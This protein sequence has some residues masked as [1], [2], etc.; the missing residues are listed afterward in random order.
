MAT[1][2]ASK[3]PAHVRG[4]HLHIRLGDPQGF[5]DQVA[6]GKWRLRAR[7]Q[8]HFTVFFHLSNRYVWFDGHMLDVRYAILAFDDRRALFPGCF[9]IPFTDAEMIG[10]IGARFREDKIG[11]LVFSEIGV[12]QRRFGAGAKFGVK[13]PWYGFVFHLDQVEG[14]FRD[15]LA[16]RRHSSHRIAH[17]A[18][19]ITAEYVAVLQVK[20][21]V[22]GER[23]AS[24]NGFDAR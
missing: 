6:L 12:E 16:D 2:K 18:D 19:S 20:P 5:S 8:R 14:L 13:D 4:D 24:D 1:A 11:D 23:L 3:P 21:Y 22:A 17:I 15:L 7:P 9:Y 10:D